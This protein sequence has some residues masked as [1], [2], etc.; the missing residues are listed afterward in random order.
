[1]AE[2]KK[3]F[4][5]SSKYRANNKYIKNNYKQVKLSM[6][7]TEADALSKYCEENNLTIAGFI[8]GLIKD[9]IGYDE[10]PFSVK[11]I[12]TDGK[13]ELVK[14]LKNVKEANQEAKIISGEFKQKGDL[15]TK[16]LL[17]TDIKQ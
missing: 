5:D 12:H 9:A 16:V 7:Y 13:E 11:V 17:S 1:M 4:K 2:D 3:T 10:M 8:R 15:E 14:T 6:P